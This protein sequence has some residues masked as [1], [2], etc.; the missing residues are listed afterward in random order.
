[1][2]G[3]YRFSEKIMRQQDLRITRK[4][5]ERSAFRAMRAENASFR[6]ERQRTRWRR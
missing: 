1:M 5:S 4:P 6:P 3:G 2:R